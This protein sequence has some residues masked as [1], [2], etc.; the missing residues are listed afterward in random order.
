MLYDQHCWRQARDAKF[1]SRHSCIHQCAQCY[2]P[3]RLLLENKI[4]FTGKSSISL[5]TS[6]MDSMIF[7]QPPSASAS[8]TSRSSV[9]RITAAQSLTS[10]APV[11]PVGIARDDTH[12]SFSQRSD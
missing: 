11:A 10:T 9:V 6:T 7:Y 4:S 2:K 12:Q 3:H 1:R 5:S 8:K